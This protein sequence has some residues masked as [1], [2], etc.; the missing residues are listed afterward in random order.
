MTPG[1]GSLTVAWNAPSQTGGSVITAY[2]LHH[3]LSDAAN[4][5]DANWTVVQDAWTGSGSLEY[6]VTGLTGGTQYDVQVRA[7]NAAGDGP[8]SATTIGIPAVGVSQPNSPTNAQYRREGST[9][10]V[11]WDPAAQAEYYKVYYSDARFPRCSL[12]PSGTPRSCEL[13]AG[14][15]AGTTYTHTSP[16]D[17]A[18]SYWIT[19]CNSAGCSDIDSANPLSSPTTGR[20]RRRTRS[21]AAKVPP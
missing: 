4:K 21:T 5:G 10:V 17:D 11:S 9:I 2:D 6:A 14:N 8:W 20:T 18:N 7:V 15:V 3:I 1:A 13:L 12:S 19:A 16:D